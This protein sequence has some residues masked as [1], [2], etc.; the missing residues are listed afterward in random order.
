M[1]VHGNT[2]Y[3]RSPVTR[4]T[5]IS[6]CDIALLFFSGNGSLNPDT[7]D[8]FENTIYTANLRALCFS[9]GEEWYSLKKCI[10]AILLKPNESR[11]LVEKVNAA[12][13]ELM[14][15]LFLYSQKSTII[16]DDL[17]EWMVGYGAE[18]I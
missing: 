11:Y 4:S 6:P 15:E 2:R 10:H 8:S 13:D 9:V 18:G 3:I 16:L 14:R 1:K 12:A 17:N 7:S 5:V